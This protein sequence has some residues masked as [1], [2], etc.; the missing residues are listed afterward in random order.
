LTRPRYEVG[1]DHI[2]WCSDFPHVVTYWPYSCEL[3][4]RQM[5]SVAADERR[6][7]KAENI[8]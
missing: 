1:V 6:K 7:M 4:D 8:S 5:C 2:I 3:L